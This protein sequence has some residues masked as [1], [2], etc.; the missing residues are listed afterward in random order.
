MNKKKLNNR[1]KLTIITC[2]FFRIFIL[3]YLK[4]IILF[5]YLILKKYKF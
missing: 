2:Y 3:V 1:E 5:I 4:I